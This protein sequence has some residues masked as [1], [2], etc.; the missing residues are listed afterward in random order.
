[1]KGLFVT[2]TDTGVGKTVV[3]AAI[4]LAL[5]ALGVD[6]GVVKPIQTGEG[7]AETLRRLAELEAEPQEI[8]PYSFA[9]PLA[10]LVSARLE[11]KT[12]DVTEVASTTL[13]LAA[14]HDVALVEGIG[15]LC[16]PIS[17]GATVVDLAVALG[18]PLAIVARAGLGTVNHT[19][20]TV[21]E[22]R[23]RDLE[24]AG[25]VLNGAEDESTATNTE[26][27]QAFTGVPVLARVPWLGGAVTSGRLRELDLHLDLAR[28]AARV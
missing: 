18:F 16:V 25:V 21:R 10:P 19:L 14:R 6:V 11:G 3:T 1:M 24:V 8:A 17:E 23:R 4:A 2:G 15:G 5:R 9:A 13:R 22:A 28:E 26:L 7:D 27:I 20:L 12:I